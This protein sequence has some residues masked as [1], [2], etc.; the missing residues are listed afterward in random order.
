M[1]PNMSKARL[2][3]VN[4]YENELKDAIKAKE[5]LEEVKRKSKG[6]VYIVSGLPRSGTSMM[7]QMLEAGG[8]KVLSDQVR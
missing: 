4:L 6:L 2:E 3:L 8:M 7:M 5:L 1:A